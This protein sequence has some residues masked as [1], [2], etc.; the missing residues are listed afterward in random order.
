MAVFSDIRP[1]AV[2]VKLS[3]MTEVKR[4]RRAVVKC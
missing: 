2:K 1:A 4:K 3:A